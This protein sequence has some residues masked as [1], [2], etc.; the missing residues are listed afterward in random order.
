MSPLYATLSLVVLQRLGELG[1]AAIHTHRLLAGGA[2]EIDTEGYK[3]FVLLHAGWLVAMVLAIPAETS[4][5]WLLLGLYVALQPVRLWLI[6]SLGSR[7]TTRLIVVPGAPVLATG[8]YRY[9]RHPNYLVVIAEIAILPLAFGAVA[10]AAAFSAANLGLI[11][12]RVRIEE[13]ALA[14]LRGH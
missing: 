12:R 5:S 13:A 1:V 14:P 9:L 6:A 10:I 3:W 11:L 2:V 7:W 8:P 4:P